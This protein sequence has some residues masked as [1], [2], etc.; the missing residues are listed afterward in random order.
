V[1]LIQ[2]RA[3]TFFTFALLHPRISVARVFEVVN[4]R[5]G[6][7]AGAES[8]CLMRSRRSITRAPLF[9]NGSN[10]GARVHFHCARR[11]IL[12]ALLSRSEWSWDGWKNEW[13]NTGSLFLILFSAHNAHA[14]LFCSRKEVA[15]INLSLLWLFTFWFLFLGQF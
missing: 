13:T 15:S 12:S 3:R 6:F 10:T 11:N 8:L 1:K 4:Y 14:D 7:A 9:G 2:P 5:S